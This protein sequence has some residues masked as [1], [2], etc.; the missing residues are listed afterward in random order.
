MRGHGDSIVEV[1]FNCH[2]CV[3]LGRLPA[4]TVIDESHAVCRL[5]IA[6]HIDVSLEARR[7]VDA[8]GRIASRKVK[9]KLMARPDFA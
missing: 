1:P 8:L 7:G 2:V 3:T 4:Q 9:G 5:E 6:D